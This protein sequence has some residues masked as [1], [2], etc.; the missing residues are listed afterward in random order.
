MSLRIEKHEEVR[1]AVV[2]LSGDVDLAAVPQVESEVSVLLESG[3]HNLVLDLA[4]VTYADSS[5]LGLLVWLDRQLDGTD[6][7]VV[8]VGADRN[9]ARVLEMSGLVSVA[10]SIKTG[11]SVEDALGGLEVVPS[12]VEPD[13]VEE[14]SILA[15]VS[16]L[17]QARERVQTLLEPLNFSTSSLFDI[18]V[19]L[20][21]ALANAVRHGSPDGRQASIQVRV[22]ALPD[23]VVIDVTDAGSG[24][25]GEH[26]VS[27]DLYASGGRGIMFMRALMDHVAF[28][29]SEDGGTVVTL[30]KHRALA[31]SA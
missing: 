12:D 13:W 14:F 4:E 31:D 20:G 24:F 11:D 30:V 26:D 25:D 8:L 16:T 18:K 17:G 1:A 3:L 6:G 21:E 29:P 10:E 19:A 27:D 22:A 28:A 2:H 5:A 15:D 9:V 23:R 7:R